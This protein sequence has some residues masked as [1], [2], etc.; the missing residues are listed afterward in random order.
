MVQG[1]FF[2]RVFGKGAYI[3]VKGEGEISAFIFA[4]PAASRAAWGENA[5][6]GAEQAL[7]FSVFPVFYE[8]ARPRFHRSA[9][10]SPESGPGLF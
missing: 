5:L 1:L 4:H 7:E 3:S 2:D 10:L 6:M 8:P 9:R